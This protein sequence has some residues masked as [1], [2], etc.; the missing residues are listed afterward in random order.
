M[1]LFEE[2]VFDDP[3]SSKKRKANDP[4]FTDLNFDL[5]EPPQ[6]AGGDF[7]LPGD[8]QMMGGSG[9]DEPLYDPIDGPQ[10]QPERAP[11]YND[12]LQFEQHLGNVGRELSDFN[13][14]SG[15]AQQEYDNFFDNSINSTY[16]DVIGFDPPPTTKENRLQHLELLESELDSNI[17]RIEQGD[18]A[19]FGKDD[20]LER[21][22]LFAS[23]DN[24][25]KIRGLRKQHDRLLANRDEYARRADEKRIERDRLIAERTQVP[26]IIRA[27]A[28]EYAKRERARRKDLERALKNGGTGSRYS[29]SPV[30]IMRIQDELDKQ[31]KHLDPYGGML[32]KSNLSLPERKRAR[33][34]LKLL[35]DQYVQDNAFRSKGGI[36]SNNGMVN[37]HPV[38]I[39]AAEREVLD[40]DALKKMGV[41]EYKGKPIEEA[42]KSLGGQERVEMLSATSSAIKLHNLY[43]QAGVEYWSQMGK[44]GDDQRKAKFDLARDSV[45]RSVHNLAAMGFSDQAIMRREDATWFSHWANAWNRGEDSLSSNPRNIMRMIAGDGGFDASH[46]EN[47]VEMAE[48][49]K[50]NPASKDLQNFQEFDAYAKKTVGEGLFTKLV[51]A[52]ERFF[53]GGRVVAL[54]CLP[55]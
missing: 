45:A 14:R 2:E 16:K 50:R 8:D 5:G 38:G 43:T 1:A 7:G 18:E 24:I 23:P 48:S 29:S 6:S 51:E 4:L 17:K 9:Y 55:R 19:W 3:F 10:P 41:A 47:L 35:S 25:R 28:R 36:V 11:L 31:Y 33:N 15:T 13:F 30:D 46:I 37:G 39:T 12:Y 40:V 42:L 26:H 52:G 22:K 32:D 49:E 54:W 44:P 27:E 53:G 20:E 34:A 21:A